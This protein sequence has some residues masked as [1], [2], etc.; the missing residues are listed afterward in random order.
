MF[1][2]HLDRTATRIGRTSGQNVGNFKEIN[3]VSGQGN[4]GQ[5]IIYPLVGL[6]LSC[7]AAFVKK[8]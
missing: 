6:H 4:S 5:K 3:A 8:H 7:Q 1:Q 2:R